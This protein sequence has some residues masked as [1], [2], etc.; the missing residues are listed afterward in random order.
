MKQFLAPELCITDTPR[1]SWDTLPASRRSGG[2]D[3]P[4]D[5]GLER[6]H[7][8]ANPVAART[9]PGFMYVRIGAD[10]VQSKVSYHVKQLLEA[11]LVTRQV[12]G[13]WSHYRLHDLELWGRLAQCLGE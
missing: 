7:P 4:R 10:A 8:G 2:R 13:A 11:G 6:L 3:D 5:Q 9:G 12:V 1:P